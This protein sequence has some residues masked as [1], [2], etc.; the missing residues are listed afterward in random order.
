MPGGRLFQRF[1]AFDLLSALPYF[2]FA[3]DDA[4]GAVRAARFL[5]KVEKPGLYDMNDVLAE[6]LAKV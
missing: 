1:G 6:L 4:N 5:A 2:L 3:S